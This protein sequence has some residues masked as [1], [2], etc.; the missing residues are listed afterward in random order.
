MLYKMLDKA[1]NSGILVYKRPR[2]LFG[3]DLD[4]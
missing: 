4:D 3:E 1:F 2:K